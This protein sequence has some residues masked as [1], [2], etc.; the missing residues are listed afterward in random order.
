MQTK[1]AVRLPAI[2]ELGM[3]LL[4]LNVLQKFW[5]LLKPF[6]FCAAYFVFA[7]WNYWLPA[8]LSVV[9]LLF[10]T[11]VSTSHDLVHR[12]L[13]LPKNINT[14]LLSLIELLVIRSGHSFRLCH[15]NHHKHFPDKKDVEGLAVHMPFYRVLLEGPIY[16]FRLFAWAWDHAKKNERAWLLTELFVCLLI[17]VCSILILPYTTILFYYV[18]LVFVGS[19]AYPLFTVYIPHMIEK[20]P[21]KQTRVFRGFFISTLFF[22]HN[23]HLEHHLYPMVPHQN[24]RK[25]AKRLDPYLNELGIK[26]IT[27]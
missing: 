13:G 27:I 3:D 8:I 16:Q 10:V 11:F 14:L 24:W 6:L 5:T 26:P 15:L 17:I 18:L 25:L 7:Y 9:C 21:V 22:Q 20:D 2:K 4:E 12:N 23:Y 19:W 1:S